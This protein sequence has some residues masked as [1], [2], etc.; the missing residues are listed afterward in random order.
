MSTRARSYFHV[1]TESVTHECLHAYLLI[2]ALCDS[3]TFGAWANLA[4]VR[5]PSMAS[6][7]ASSS[8]DSQLGPLKSPKRFSSSWEAVQASAHMSIVSLNLNMAFFSNCPST[9]SGMP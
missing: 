6:P 8:L 7:S 2:C 5:A 3:S 4:S 9:P 1:G